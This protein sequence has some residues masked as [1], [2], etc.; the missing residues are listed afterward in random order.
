[1]LKLNYQHAN[2]RFHAAAYLLKKSYI[3]RL[4]KVA[5]DNVNC[6]AKLTQLG[7]GGD[8]RWNPNTSVVI[9]S[10]IKSGSG[11]LS[12]YRSSMGGGNPIILSCDQTFSNIVGPFQRTTLE[13]NH[14]GSGKATPINIKISDANLA[15]KHASLENKKSRKK[16]NGKSAPQME[17]IYVK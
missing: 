6:F 7:G 5:F 3:Y 11:C 9:D 17:R 13:Q 8:V 2:Q 14:F 1:M 12:N 10:A 15:S 4:K 16:S